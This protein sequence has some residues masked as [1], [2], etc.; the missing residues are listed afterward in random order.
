MIKTEIK[1]AILIKVLSGANQGSDGVELD[2]AAQPIAGL[3]I[4]AGYSYNNARYTKR[5]LTKGELHRRR[6]LVNNPLILLMRASFVHSI[7]KVI[8]EG[9]NIWCYCPSYIGDRLGGT[10]I[11]V[12]QTQDLF[13][14]DP[15]LMAIL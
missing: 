14:G 1:I 10:T 4:L 7:D 3:S 6:K 13:K 15:C 9:F 8:Q 12:G 5:I 11:P 2:V